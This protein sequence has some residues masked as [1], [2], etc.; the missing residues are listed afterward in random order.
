MRPVKFNIGG[1]KLGVTVGWDISLP[2]FTFHLWSQGAKSANRNLSLTSRRASRFPCEMTDSIPTV[3]CESSLLSDFSWSM[4]TPESNQHGNELKGPVKP[5]VEREL[6]LLMPAA[7]KIHDALVKHV[8][9]RNR[10]DFLWE[11]K[12]W[13]SLIRPSE[14]TGRPSAE[15]SICHI[16]LLSLCLHH[17]LAQLLWINHLS[18]FISPPLWCYSTHGFGSLAF[19]SL[20]SGR[21]ISV[22]RPSQKPADPHAEA[23]PNTKITHSQ[24]SNLRSRSCQGVVIFRP[25]ILSIKNWLFNSKWW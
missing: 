5:N 19:L 3:G 2:S 9:F 14:I 8:W 20:R 6:E 12:A 1:G 10:T 11:E 16:H 7:R 21:I 17:V 15:I 18:G 25:A 23:H 22:L 13:W 24:L 4:I